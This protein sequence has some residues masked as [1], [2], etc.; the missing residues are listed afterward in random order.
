M[1]N[2]SDI[3]EGR[4]IATK[5]YVDTKI[6]DIKVDLPTVEENILTWAETVSPEINVSLGVTNAS[7]GDIIKVKAVDENGIPTVWEKAEMPTKKKL[8][9]ENWV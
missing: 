7:I 2:L 4:D 9:Q 6:A 1:K 8:L 5:N 3:T